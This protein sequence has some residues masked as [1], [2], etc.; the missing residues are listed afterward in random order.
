MKKICC[1]CSEGVADQ[2]NELISLVH[3]YTGIDV[4]LL[5]STESVV[6][7]E[8]AIFVLSKDALKDDTV[9]RHLKEA[10]DLNRTFI[11]VIVGGN[12]LSSWLLEKKYKGPN[13]RTEI[14]H[15]RKDDQML[16][17]MKQL[18]SYGGTEIHGDVYGAQVEILADLPYRIIRD[19]DI[20]AETGDP[21][22]LKIYL[23]KGVHKLTLQ[24]IEYPEM[25]HEITV[26]VKK[27][28]SP[29]RIGVVIAKH[30]EVTK[31]A[32]DDGYYEGSIY[33]RKRD[34]YG[35][36][37]YPDGSVYRGDWKD[38]SPSGKGIK[39]YADGSTYDGD[40]FDGNQ[41]GY[42]TIYRPDGMMEY[43]GEW[44]WGDYN[45]SGIR[46]FEDGTKYEGH[47]ENGSQNGV[48]TLYGSN[49]KKLYEGEWEYDVR[50]GFGIEYD[51][52]GR[53]LYEG[54]WN[55]DLRHGHGIEYDSRGKVDF[56][57]EWIHGEKQTIFRK[58]TN[59]FRNL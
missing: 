1:I 2:A 26:K 42:G 36:F 16:A 55:N 12:M 48:G 27:I 6:D 47:W 35:T 29:Q 56:E 17:F 19:K 18:A 38:D 54:E 49:D 13:L 32:Y 23:Y 41:H 28:S 4:E 20:I 7:Y 58:I 45:G 15:L 31:M 22:D 39:T 11:P 40:W 10:S 44:E 53:K 43:Q 9:A 14:L 25:T 51:S 8:V 50:Q 33:F 57:G 46:F 24:S 37:W 34:G 3:K 59:W 21:R 5:L 52:R 30:I